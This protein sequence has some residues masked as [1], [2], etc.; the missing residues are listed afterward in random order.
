MATLT[1]GGLPSHPNIVQYTNKIDLDIFLDFSTDS[2]RSLRRLNPNGEFRYDI[3]F[4]EILKHYSNTAKNVRLN[5]K[6]QPSHAEKGNVEILNDQ[7]QIIRHTVIEINKFK[8]MG[9]FEGSFEMPGRLQ[10][11]TQIRNAAYFYN[12][13][14]EVAWSFRYKVGENRWKTLDLGCSLDKD[15]AR[16]AKILKMRGELR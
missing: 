11:W 9:A 2:P 10:A 14:P 16:Y 4:L 13:H 12:I 1:Q 15:L 5:V 7:A 8:H 6:F 3:T